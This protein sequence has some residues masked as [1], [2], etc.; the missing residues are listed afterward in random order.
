MGLP[1][2]LKPF[3]ATKVGLERLQPF[4]VIY[5]WALMS[6]RFGDKQ[7]FVGVLFTSRPR[8]RQGPGA[9]GGGLQTFSQ[10]RTVV[11]ST[12][13]S[14]Y[15]EYARRDKDQGLELC[16]RPIPDEGLAMRVHQRLD[17]TSERPGGVC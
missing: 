4:T 17:F 1:E 16:G 5:L 11:L 3:N 10:W 13:K 15:P 2:E 6:A 14:L 8:K 9:K 12:G 7:S